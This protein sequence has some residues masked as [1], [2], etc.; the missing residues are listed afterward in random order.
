MS[1][2]IPPEGA[3]EEQI[4]RFVM[5]L[6]KDARKRVRQMLA[7]GAPEIEIVDYVAGLE[8]PSGDAISEME[9]EV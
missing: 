6:R 1:T 5:S 2:V 7:S 4:E 9:G 8:K 3:T